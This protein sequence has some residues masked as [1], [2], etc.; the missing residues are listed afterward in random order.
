MTPPAGPI[1][2]LLALMARLRDPARGCPWDRAQTFASIA[3]YTIEE[4]Y[5]VAD[6]IARGDLDHL[7]EELGD[8][9]FQ[10]VFH[11]EMAREA[12]AFDF[13]AVVSSLLDKMT[14]RHPH[15]FGASDIATA[16]AQSAAW[17]A[18]KAR[19][20]AALARAKG[21]QPSVLDGV[22]LALPAL[23][24][25]VKLQKRLASVGF[26]WT[27]IE[28]VLVKLREELGELE[29]ALD[30]DA[31]H[32]AE[33]FGDLLFVCANLSRFLDIEP[34]TALRRANAKVER[35]FR[36]IEAH[37]AARGLAPQDVDLETLDSLW[38]QVKREEKQAPRD[39]SAG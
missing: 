18:L 29:A 11:A 16:E 10:V 2:A 27:R 17:E 28:D 22:P 24:R 3:P 34:E 33:E 30:G 7:R 20:R 19:E 13:S 4:A 21:E 8:L 36:A 35:R 14:R 25:A 23:T 15:I 32:I 5:E 12:G 39:Q 1:E 26:D 31:D 9:L 38:D 37:L 6:A